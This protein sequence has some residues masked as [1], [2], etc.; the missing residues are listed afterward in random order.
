MSVTGLYK[1]IGYKDR[2]FNDNVHNKTVKPLNRFCGTR[3]F[4]Y[5]VDRFVFRNITFKRDYI[6]KI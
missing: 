5:I 4:F 1:R 6:S 3:S 2:L